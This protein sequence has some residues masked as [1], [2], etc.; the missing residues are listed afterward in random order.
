MFQENSIETCILSRV[1]QI[2]GPGWMHE[3]SARSHPF[4]K[5]Y[6]FFTLLGITLPYPL[7]YFFKQC[8]Q[9]LN[10]SLSEFA[11][12]ISSVP[13]SGTTPESSLNLSI[14]SQPR[15]WL[16]PSNSEES[17]SEGEGITVESWRLRTEISF[18][19]KTEFGP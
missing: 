15:H 1:K 14:C 18:C 17:N 16:E 19:L 9:S 3:T 6:F 5:D 12:S 2:T 4:L 11:A 13:S 10:S 7:S 8:D